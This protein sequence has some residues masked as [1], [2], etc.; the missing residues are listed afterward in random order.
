MKLNTKILL[1][2]LLA[3][4]L[5][6]L[7]NN[8]F[9]T[10]T[11]NYNGLFEY[12]INNNEIIITKVNFDFVENSNNN[13]MRIPS[14]IDGSPIIGFNI[15]ADDTKYASQDGVLYNK[16]KTILYS[17]P[18]G[19][20]ASSFTIPSTVKKIQ[21]WAFCRCENLEEVKIPSGITN[22]PEGAFAQSYNL[23][24]VTIPTG[25]K[26][27]GA[28]AFSETSLIEVVIPNTVTKIWYGAF[29]DCPNLKTVTIP[30]S[31]TFLGDDGNGDGIFDWDMEGELLINRIILRVEEGSYA[32][33]YA[34]NNKIKYEIIDTKENEKVN[35]SNNSIKIDTTTNVIPKNT[36]L[37]VE[38]VSSGNNYNIVTEAIEQDVNKFI[39]YDISLESNNAKIQP[40]GKVKVSIPLP[41]NYDK[42]KIV[43]YRVEDNGNKVE[44]TTKIENINNQDYVVFETDHFSNYVVAEKKSVNEMQNEQTKK[45]EKEEH[46]LDNEPKTGIISIVSILAV[47]IALSIVGVVISKNKM[48]K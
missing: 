38:E 7:C 5:I 31:V 2:M 6:L 35:L 42:T 17:Y 28:S 14:Q 8:V 15:S 32:K 30:S 37:L 16:D 22:I 46:I 44:Y 40:N 1:S 41:T 19:K 23:T 25:V 12:E 26:D 3:V 47:A 4:I 34:Q 43:V 24:S 21:N 10:E 39:L 29:F 9:A 45:E 36:K 13:S 48:Y 27:I 33:K 11:L 18:K 20:N